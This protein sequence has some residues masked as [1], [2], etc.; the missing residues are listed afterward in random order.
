MDVMSAKGEHHAPR[1]RCFEQT[2]TFTYQG[3]QFKILFWTNSLH[4]RY[5]KPKGFLHAR[6]IVYEGVRQSYL[7]NIINPFKL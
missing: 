3:F 6:P 2:I 7:C 1:S 5:K 4:Y